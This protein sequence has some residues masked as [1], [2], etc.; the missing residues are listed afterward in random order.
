[1][2]NVESSKELPEALK[3]LNIGNYDYSKIPDD[4]LVKLFYATL[5][6]GGILLLIEFMKRAN[7][8]K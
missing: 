1:M 3:K 5:G 7:K 6:I 2:T 4:P 8:K